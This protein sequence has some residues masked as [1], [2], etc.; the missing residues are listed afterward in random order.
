MPVLGGVHASTQGVGHLPVVA[1]LEDWDVL[2]RV[3]GVVN[4]WVSS[5]SHKQKDMS[6]VMDCQRPGLALQE[7][8]IVVGST[9]ITLTPVS[10][11]EQAPAL[12]LRERGPVGQHLR[13]AATLHILLSALKENSA[14]AFAFKF[15]LNQLSIDTR[16]P[17]R[18]T[19]SISRLIAVT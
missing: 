3:R 4:T 14:S 16:Y 15:V 10:S 2:L 8:R 9:L 7:D 6:D 17:S 1:L 19:A 13:L 11:T 18:D 12:S 5:G